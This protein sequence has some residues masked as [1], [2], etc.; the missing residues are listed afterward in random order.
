MPAAAHL[1]PTSGDRPP[2]KCARNTE[3]Q[4]KKPDAKRLFFVRLRLAN[5]YYVSWVGG[6][7]AFFHHSHFV[8]EVPPL[9]FDALCYAGDKLVDGLSD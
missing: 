4:K 6:I 9:A 5:F 1:I 3:I 7:F 2:A 8:F